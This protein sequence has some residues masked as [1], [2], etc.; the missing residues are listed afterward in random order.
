MAKQDVM[1]IIAKVRQDPALTKQFTENPQATL[2]KLG[3]DTTGLNVQKVPPKPTAAAAPA[4][5]EA[6][7][8]VSVG[9]IACASVG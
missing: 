8:C 3:V 7:F 4:A 9:C 1:D 2:Q 5:A 6:A